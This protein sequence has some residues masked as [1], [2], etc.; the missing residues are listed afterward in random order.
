MSIIPILGT[1]LPIPPCSSLA[2]SVHAALI[3]RP[4]FAP[5]LPMLLGRSLG[6]LFIFHSICA[7]C[8]CL[9]LVPMPNSHSQAWV[10]P[11]LAVRLR[12]KDAQSLRESIISIEWVTTTLSR[13]APASTRSMAYAHQSAHPIRISLVACSESRSIL[14]DALWF[15][16]FL[17]L[18]WCHAI[19]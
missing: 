2:F 4:S 13:L 7:K 8:V 15:G 14:T 1:A 5:H 6:T 17:H 11:T 12:L 19:R 18:R 9:R 10:L 16:H 3:R